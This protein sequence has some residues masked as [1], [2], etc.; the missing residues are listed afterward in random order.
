MKAIILNSKQTEKILNHLVAYGF[1]KIIMFC[2]STIDINRSYYKMNGIDIIMVNS[3]AREQT[4]DKLQKIRGSLKDCFLI[5][6]SD[7]AC[8]YDLDEALKIHRAKQGIITVTQRDS[9]ISFAICEPEVLDYF[10]NDTVS[11]EKDVIQRIAE[12]SELTVF[13]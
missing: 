3:I 8:S 6:Y 4:K 5:V 10:T 12:D 7:E 13:E 1:D 9:K 11:F 2:N